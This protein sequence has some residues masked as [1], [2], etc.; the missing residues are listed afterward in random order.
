[1]TVFVYDPL[2]EIADAGIGA[3]ICEDEFLPFNLNGNDPIAPSSSYWYILEGP[4][5]LS[6]F[7]IT[8]PEV[9]TLGEITTPLQGVTTVFVYTIDNGVCGTTADTVA[10]ILDDCLTIDIPDAFSP[11]ADNINDT[12]FIPNLYK[13]PNNSLKIFN[14][15]GNLIYEAA[16]YDGTWNGTNNQSALFGDELPVSTYYYIL[17]LG[18]GSEPFAGFVFLQR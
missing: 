16:P 17:D 7:N 4:G 18:D 5:E 1:M 12:W 2:H 9:T 8:D 10:F 6:D 14:R 15:W 11:N 3:I 13:Y